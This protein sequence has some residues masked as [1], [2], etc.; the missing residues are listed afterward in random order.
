MC[1]NE[2]SYYNS[3]MILSIMLGAAW[4]YFVTFSSLNSIANCGPLYNLRWWWRDIYLRGFE[5]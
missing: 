1:Y 5:V 2:I 4:Y 3:S